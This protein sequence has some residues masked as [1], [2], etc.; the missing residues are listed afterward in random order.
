[1][2]K[3]KSLLLPYISA[4]VTLVVFANTPAFAIGNPEF[5]FLTPFSSSVTIDFYNDRTLDEGLDSIRFFIIAAVNPLTAID[6]L[7][8]SL[9]ATPKLKDYEGEVTYILFGLGG[10]ELAFFGIETATF[11][12]SY[13]NSIE[14]TL[15]IN[16][17]AG[18]AIAG[19][20]LVSVREAD[21]DVPFTLRVSASEAAE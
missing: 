10:A 5:I 4:A 16:S 14:K 3:I 13:S 21:G 15:S 12:T 17:L 19:M 2:K 18:L 9:R 8:I 20:A 1:M 11:S 6:S 7:T